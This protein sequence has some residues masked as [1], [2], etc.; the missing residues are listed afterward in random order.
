MQ[1][2]KIMN[3]TT[4]HRVELEPSDIK[5]EVIFNGKVVAHTERAL[6]VRETGYPDVYYLPEADLRPEFFEDSAR[7]THCPYKGEARYMHLVDGDSRAEDA[8]W[9][10]PDPIPG[11]EGLAGHVAFYRDRVDSIGVER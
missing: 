6:I 10:Y 9:T 5:V 1:K 4:L 2:E 7:K 3:M 11:V 8:V